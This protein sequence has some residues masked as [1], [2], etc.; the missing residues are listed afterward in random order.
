M[1]DHHCKELLNNICGRLA[2]INEHFFHHPRSFLEKF[3][4]ASFV[5]THIPRLFIYS[6]YI[7]NVLYLTTVE[8]TDF[9]IKVLEDSIQYISKDFIK[10]LFAVEEIDIKSSPITLHQNDNLS[11]VSTKVAVE[12]NVKI[13]P[14]TYLPISAYTEGE[15]V[16]VDF[17]EGALHK[18]D[19]ASRF[20][21]KTCFNSKAILPNRKR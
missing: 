5:T 1:R 21:G 15:D 19:V 10:T 13:T 11:F 16:K 8:A 9:D 7:Y 18:A 6:Q 12:I 3:I 4:P 17:A 14:E 2:H 20:T